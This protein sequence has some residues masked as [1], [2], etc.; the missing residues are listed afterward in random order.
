[1]PRSK[2][3]TA[4]GGR[5]ELLRPTHVR[6][7]VTCVG[8]WQKTSVESGAHRVAEPATLWHRLLRTQEA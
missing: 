3:Q 2:E 6:T 5:T 8:L 4:R 1:M 7:V